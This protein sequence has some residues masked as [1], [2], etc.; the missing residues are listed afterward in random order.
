[1]SEGLEHNSKQYL[2]DPWSSLRSMTSARIALGRSGSSVPLRESLNFKLAHAHARDAVYSILNAGELMANLSAFNISIH[3]LHSRA[4]YRQEYL[5]RPDL[6]RRLNDVSAEHLKSLDIKSG[7][8]VALIVADGLS[9]TAINRHASHV[10]SKLITNLNTQEISIAPI[11]I[12]EHGRVAISDEIGAL[13]NAKVAVIFI[14][15]RPG[16][17]AYDSMGAYLTFNPH[18]GLT[19]DSRNCVANIRPEG[20]DYELATAK[21]LYLIKESLRLKMSGVMLKENTNHLR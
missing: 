17:S 7:S 21:I 8:D 16:L 4:F 12:V 6:G 1:M 14:G 9:A 15:E 3:K 11:T 2:K 10:L 19:D 18:I 5:Q 13:L 20:L